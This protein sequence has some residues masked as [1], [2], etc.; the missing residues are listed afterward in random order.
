MPPILVVI[1]NVLGHEP[2]QMAFIQ[3]NYMVEQIA[4]ARTHEAFCDSILPGT[5]ERG[6]NWLHPGSLDCLDDLAVEGSVAVEDRL[7]RCG[8]IWKGLSQLLRNPRTGRMPRGI[9]KQNAPSVMSDHEE[10]IGQTEGERRDGEDI[11]CSDGLAVIVEKRRPTFC[12][13][14]IEEPCAS[15]AVRS[16]R[17]YQIRAF[18]IPHECAAL[19]RLGFRQP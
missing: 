11:H 18:S 5:L 4:A 10:A 12:R 15:S 8:V 13:L 2:F 14:A 6:A 1:T 7:A 3:H 17:R 9:E 19:P 16:A